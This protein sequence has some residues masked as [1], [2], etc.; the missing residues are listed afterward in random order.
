MNKKEIENKI[1]KI[2]IDHEYAWGYD[3]NIVEEIINVLNQKNE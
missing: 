1:R 2:L 3:D